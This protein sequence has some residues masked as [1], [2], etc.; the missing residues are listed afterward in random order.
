MNTEREQVVCAQLV[1]YALS[2]GIPLHQRT[3]LSDDERLI[4][5]AKW[6]ELNAPAT[7]Q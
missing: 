1:A 4:L 7:R 5:E 3:H 6:R 2:Q